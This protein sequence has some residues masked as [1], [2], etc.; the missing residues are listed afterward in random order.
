MIW[1]NM[2]FTLW[3]LWQ[4]IGEQDKTWIIVATVGL[5]LNLG[6]VLKFI[7]EHS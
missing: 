4:L 1:L 5:T 6:L 2:F 3:Y 7:S